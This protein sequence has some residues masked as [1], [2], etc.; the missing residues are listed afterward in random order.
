MVDNFVRNLVTRSYPKH[1]V[2]ENFYDSVRTSPP[3]AQFFALSFLIGSSVKQYLAT[4]FV[5]ILELFQVIGA[6]MPFTGFQEFITSQLMNFLYSIEENC[7]ILGRFASLTRGAFWASL[8]Q[9]CW[10]VQ[11]PAIC[12]QGGRCTIMDR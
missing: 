7:H 1:N 4:Y 6:L 12:H 9:V 5:L 2:R 8:N 11:F 3:I 10:K